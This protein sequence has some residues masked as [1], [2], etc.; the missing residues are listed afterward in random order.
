MIISLIQLCWFSFFLPLTFTSVS[1]NYTIDPGHTYIGWDVERFMVGEVT[2]NFNSYTA[3]INV[4]G[5]NL[6]TLQFNV[7]ID[8]ASINSGHE[9]RDGHLKSEIWLD[10][11]NHP[12]IKFES[13][14][15]VHK[16]DNDFMVSGTFTIHGVSKDI[17]FP[18]IIQGPFKDPTQKWSIGLKADFT[19]NRMDYGIMFSKKMDNGTLFIGKDVKIKI[20]ALAY[21]EG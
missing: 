10:V 16:E 18:A 11:E 7:T 21:K 17:E 20:R 4:E 5:D 1:D 6:N 8:A 13:T 12:E 19:I 15:V 2:G 14:K 3:E 9:V